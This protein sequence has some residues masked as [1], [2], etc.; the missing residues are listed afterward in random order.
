ME[1]PLIISIVIIGFIIFYFYTNKR[2]YK[3]FQHKRDLVLKEVVKF[4]HEIIRDV[5]ILWF[6]GKGISGKSRR[7]DGEIIFLNHSLI[8]IL[9]LPNG[10]RGKKF[11]QPIIQFNIDGQAEELAGISAIEHL[12]SLGLEESRLSLYFTKDTGLNK[13][14]SKVKLEFGQQAGR[15][16]LVS[17]K[18]SYLSEA[19]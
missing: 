11:P 10:G 19:V 15:F 17:E 18:F 14:E 13:F 8:L 3:Y 1:Y 2:I 7:F 6:S 16:Q 5:R 12:D 9:H 4:E